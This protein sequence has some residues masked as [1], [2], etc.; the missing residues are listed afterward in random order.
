VQSDSDGDGEDVRGHDDLG[1]GAASGCITRARSSA[2]DA[3]EA[4]E[5]SSNVGGA[6]SRDTP[7]APNEPVAKAAIAARFRAMFVVGASGPVEVREPRLVPPVTFQ[8]AR[9]LVDVSVEGCDCNGA[10]LSESFGNFDKRVAADW[11]L[12]DLA[13]YP[14]LTREQAVALGAKA[15]RAVAASKVAVRD[16]R[17]KALAPARAAGEDEGRAQ[18]AAERAALSADAAI[19]MPPQQ[20]AASGPTGSRKRARVRSPT[21]EEVYQ[22]EVASAE[23]RLLSA[24]REV[25]R[26]EAAVESADEKEA[27]AWARFKRASERLKQ[28]KHSEKFA[29]HE[30][31][32]K[33]DTRHRD[34]EDGCHEAEKSFLRAQLAEKDA[35]LE[36]VML[37]WGYTAQGLASATA[38]AEECLDIARK[39]C[40][41]V[42]TQ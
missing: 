18:D 29:C 6:E 10:A 24:E 28:C 26:A 9:D 3:A 16:A 5:P 2:A 34:A 40:D 33:A 8:V 17:K 12:A 27:L 21:R 22:Q 35:E 1:R 20:P 14:L 30:Q 7:E 23:E 19:T 42:N 39:C 41:A 37:Q 31:F 15:Q 25:K 13:G 4:G 32:S 38:R 36:L 11:L